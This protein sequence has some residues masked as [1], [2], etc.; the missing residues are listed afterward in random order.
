MESSDFSA[1]IERFSGYADLYDRYRPDPPAILAEILTRLANAPRPDLVVDLGSGTGRSTR[2][3]AGIARQVI[4]IEPTADMRR[5]AEALTS[6]QTIS[7]LEGFSH[8]TG[9]PDH[10]AQI[11]TCIQSLHWMDPPRTFAEA[12]R[13]LQPGGI[14][15]ASSYDWPPTT[16]SWEADQAFDDCLRRA[17]EMGREV[18]SIRRVK[19][20]DKSGHLDRMRASGCFRFTKEIAVHHIDS[21]NADR[22][23]GLALSQGALMSLV[24]IGVSEAELGV[25]ALR[26]TARRALGEMLRPWYW[27]A[28]VRLGVV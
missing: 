22:L 27:T 18:E 28:R 10:C 8:E 21:G 12:K 1:N 14:F 23:V 3:W 20:W 7:Y 4:G 13:I 16:G 11:I 25:E 2:Y 17:R 6:D 24:K 5:Q 19:Q 9:L 15:A 26:E